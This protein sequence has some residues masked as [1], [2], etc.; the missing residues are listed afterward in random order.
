MTQLN[1]HI[2]SSLVSVKESYTP[3]VGSD[4]IILS[5]NLRSIVSNYKVKYISV[6]VNGVF[7]EEADDY[8]FDSKTGT[9]V[10]ANKFDSEEKVTI[11]VAYLAGVPSYINSS[12]EEAYERV[13]YYDNFPTITQSSTQST[14]QRLYLYRNG[15]ECTAVTGGLEVTNTR[16]MSCTL[17]ANYIS[18]IPNTSGGYFRDATIHTVNKIDF[19]NWNSIHMSFEDYITNTYISQFVLK[20]STTRQDTVSNNLDY[21]TVGCTEGLTYGTSTKNQLF[22]DFDTYSDSNISNSLIRLS[23][24]TEPYYLSLCYVSKSNQ[25]GYAKVYAI[26]LE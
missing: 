17:E 14:S 20:I 26:W 13:K 24:L 3:I 6:Y 12:Y 25:T 9:F 8:T 5:S 19:F 7:Y 16:D 18:F 4:Y 10:F 22:V 11:T 21:G 2:L 23:E 15:D 1:K